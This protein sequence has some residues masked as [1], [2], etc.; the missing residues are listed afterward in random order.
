MQQV[1]SYQVAD[2]I[3]I[4]SVKNAFKAKLYYSDSDELFYNID[5]NQFIYVFKYGVACFYNCSPQKISEFL[6]FISSFCKNRFQESL[7]EEYSINTYANENRI[8]YSQMDIV[9]EDTEVLRLIM[10]NVS[11]SVALDYYYELTKKL[12]EETNFHTQILATK[13]R[14]GITG[15]NLKK[16]I[17]TSLLLKNRIAE[18]LYIFDSPDETWDN[19]NLSK[20]DLDLKRTFDL[21]ERT[22]TIQEGLTIIKDN[23]EL[24]RALLQYRHSNML[25]WIVIILILIE[26]INVFLEKMGH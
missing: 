9:G 5:T 24:F 22:R 14:L 21:Q 1:L 17:G 26:V 19:E 8:G 23:L 10:L 16:Y 15:I 11:Q 18:N 7:S 2:S 4:K 25:E 12:L 6:A 3:D 13:G 20:I